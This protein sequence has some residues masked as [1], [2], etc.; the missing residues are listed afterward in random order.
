[1]S[2]EGI[3]DLGERKLAVRDESARNVM[4]GDPTFGLVEVDRTLRDADNKI[5]GGVGVEVVGEAVQ[6]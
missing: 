1:M 2:A 4:R 6:P 3:C 5:E